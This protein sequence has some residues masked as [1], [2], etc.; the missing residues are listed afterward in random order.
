MV[1]DI[2]NFLLRS[3]LFRSVIADQ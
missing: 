3:R 1:K 2:Y